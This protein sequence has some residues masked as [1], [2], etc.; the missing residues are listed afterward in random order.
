MNDDNSKRLLRLVQQ[1]QAANRKS[2]LRKDREDRNLSRAL[3]SQ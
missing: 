1:V 3:A 2:Q